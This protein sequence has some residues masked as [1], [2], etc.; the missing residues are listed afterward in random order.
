MIQTMKK[1]EKQFEKNK[2][3]KSRYEYKSKTS[4]NIEEKGKIF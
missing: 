1:L 4:I 3:K 2:D